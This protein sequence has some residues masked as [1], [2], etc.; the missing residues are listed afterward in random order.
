MEQE[1]KYLYTVY[2]EG[3][4]SK[5]AEKLYI[6]QPALSISIQK[7]EQSIGMPLFDRSK[8][9]LQLTEAGQIYMDTINK[10]MQLEHEMDQRFKDLSELTTGTVRIGGSHYLNA[11]ILPEIL[12][13]FCRKYPG[14]SL[15]IMEAGSYALT[16]MLANDQLD[17]TFSCHPQYLK[18]FRKYEMFEDHIL[19]AVPALNPI[20][21]SLA[22][23][24]LTAEDVL[25]QKHLKDSCPQVE[26]CTFAEL[27]FILLRKGNNLHDRAWDMF[28]EAGFEPKIKLTL[29]QLVTACRL[30]A[31]NMAATFVSDH[32]IG[33]MD[34]SLCYYKLHSEHTT[35]MFYI[36]LPNKDYVPVAV[37]KMMEY[38][39]QNAM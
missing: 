2:Q 30:A 5:A 12:T 31:A 34:N 6:T 10:Q 15:E 14:V 9:P 33:P 32:M 4:F 29:S 24:A 20:N 37:K 27:E 16:E 35:R 39:R 17:M 38:I 1:K 3:S 11:Y 7:L 21:R 25:R 36:L 26:L 8:R 23:C 19:L 13:G 18:N 28:R 22:N